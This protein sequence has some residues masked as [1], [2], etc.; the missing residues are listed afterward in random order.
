MIRVRK[1]IDQGD[2]PQFIPFCDE[3]GGLPG[4]RGRIAGNIDNPVGLEA[5]NVIGCL[6][7]APHTGWVQDYHIR[8]ETGTAQCGTNLPLN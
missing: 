8:V 7:T 5:G 6:D 1:L 2:P 3:C 4:K